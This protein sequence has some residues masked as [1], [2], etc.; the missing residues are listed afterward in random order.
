MATKKEINAIV[1][2]NT[3]EEGWMFFA[4]QSQA[5]L[6]GLGDRIA[7]SNTALQEVVNDLLEVGIDH[8]TFLW[9]I[10]GPRK[11]PEKNFASE[12]RRYIA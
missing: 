10:F 1:A 9:T 11:Q 8:E 4:F 12:L 5:G 2:R 6:E 7:A 3:P